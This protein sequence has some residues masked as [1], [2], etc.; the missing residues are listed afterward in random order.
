MAH[1]TYGLQMEHGTWRAS[2]GCGWRSAPSADLAAST[3]DLDRH[4]R[5]VVTGQQRPGRVEGVVTASVLQVVDHTL[6][7]GVLAACLAVAAPLA[8]RSRAS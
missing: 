5:V 6:A 7:L 4:L 3:D 2:C 1:T 8:A